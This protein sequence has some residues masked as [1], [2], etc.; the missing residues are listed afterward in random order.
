MDWKEELGVQLKEGRGDLMWR[1]E[2]VSG[3][4]EIHPNMV[5]RY[6]R[7]ESGPELDVLIKLAVAL[8][9]WEFRVGD[10]VVLIKPAD[11]V[12]LA[13][14]RPRQLRL[15]YGKE[16][17][18]VHGSPERIPPSKEPLLIVPGQKKSSR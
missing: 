10:Y 9:K 1:Q 17:V 7:G 2:D 14:V 12:A 3:R 4:V 8:D 11:E 15:E 13:P 16:Y 5:G 18:F 6:E